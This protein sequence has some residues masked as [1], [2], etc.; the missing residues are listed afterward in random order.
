MGGLIQE[1]LIGSKTAEQA[2]NESNAKI[3]EI[4]NQ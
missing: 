1:A 3:A 4:V 2:L